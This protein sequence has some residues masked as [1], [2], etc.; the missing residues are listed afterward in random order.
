MIKVFKEGTPV[1]IFTEYGISYVGLMG[2]I[3]DMFGKNCDEQCWNGEYFTVLPLPIDKLHYAESGWLSP[4]HTMIVYSETRI[5]L[6]DVKDTN[7]LITDKEVDERN[8]AIDKHNET[9]QK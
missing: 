9:R 1:S 8:E 7:K 5:A 6:K 3:Y 2:T 4:G